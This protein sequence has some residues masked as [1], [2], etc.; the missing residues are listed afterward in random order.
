MKLKKL[1]SA[2]LAGALAFSLSAPAFASVSYSEELGQGTEYEGSLTTPTIKIHVPESGAVALNPYKLTIKVDATSGLP[3]SNGTAENTDQIISPTN[4]ITNGSDVALNVGVTVT[5]KLP[6]GKKDVRFATAST[7]PAAGKAAATTND[8]FMYFE[9]DNVDDKNEPTWPDAYNGTKPAQ[10]QTAKQVLVKN[11][12][13]TVANII[14]LGATSA[15]GTDDTYAAYRLTGDLVTA[16]TRAWVED[17][18]VSVAVA[19]TFTP[20]VAAS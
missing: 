20:C 7:V 9:I 12:A 8:I 6:D 11:G 3:A 16:P 19:F 5:G 15:D 13:T 1:V 2:V 18:A 4:Y 14:T 17:D 10:G